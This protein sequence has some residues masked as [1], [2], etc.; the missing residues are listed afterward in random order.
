MH[1]KICLHLIICLNSLIVSY[2]CITRH[3]YNPQLFYSTYCWSVNNDHSFYNKKCNVKWKLQI[4]KYNG[5]NTFKGQFNFKSIYYPWFWAF[6]M[7]PQIKS[8]QSDNAC[9]KMIPY[10]MRKDI[11]TYNWQSDQIYRGKKYRQLTRQGFFLSKVIAKDFV[12]FNSK[13]ILKESKSIFELVGVYNKAFSRF[14]LP[15]RSRFL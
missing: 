7:N 6:H 14:H 9:H 12:H 11:C 5:T 8:T 4:L 1:E 13:S 2:L 10:W 3:N 15:F